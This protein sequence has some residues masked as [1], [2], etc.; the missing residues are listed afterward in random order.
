VLISTNFTG[1]NYEQ[2]T[3]TDLHPTLAPSTSANY[4]WV[5]SGEIDL[6][7]YTGIG[8]IAFTYTGSNTESSTFAIDNFVFGEKGNLGGGG[9]NTGTGSGTFDDPYDV[10]IHWG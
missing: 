8:Y 10:D 3:W 7:S 9:G 4:S 2:A 6:S 1:A 5:E